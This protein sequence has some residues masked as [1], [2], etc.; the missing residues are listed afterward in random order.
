MALLK[1]KATMNISSCGF[2]KDQKLL[3]ATCSLDFKANQDN[4][5]FWF[6]LFSIV[7]T[8]TVI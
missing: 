8:I 2:G 3:A 4:A 6:F 5:S 7:L 1:H